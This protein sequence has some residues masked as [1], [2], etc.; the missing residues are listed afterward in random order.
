MILYMYR[1]SWPGQT[2][3]REQ[4]FDFS[5]NFVILYHLC[6]FQTIKLKMKALG[7]SQGHMAI[8]NNQEYVT[9]VRIQI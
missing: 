1:T 3:Q 9:P 2:T 5:R 7:L 8:S 4:I 6:K